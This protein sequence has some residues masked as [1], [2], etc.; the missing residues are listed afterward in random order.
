MVMVFGEITTSAKVDYEAIVRKTCRD[1]GFTSAEVGLDADTCKVPSRALCPLW[2]SAHEPA[3]FSLASTSAALVA[4]NALDSARDPGFY[5]TSWQAS[6][7][8]VLHP[9]S[10]PQATPPGLFHTSSALHCP[11]TQQR[12]R[13]DQGS[14]HSLHHH[15]CNR[16]LS[17]HAPPYPR[18]PPPRLLPP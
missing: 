18:Q 7:C 17:C 12:I 8:A 9:H 13:P 1:I 15:H 14:R 3:S 10:S 2:A 4:W 6:T 11:R 5:Y 16:R